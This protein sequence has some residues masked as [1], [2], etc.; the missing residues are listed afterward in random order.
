MGNI[1]KMRAVIKL[2]K[3]YWQRKY[4]TSVSIPAEFLH[5]LDFKH[6]LK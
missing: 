1:K 3:K 2:A 6:L 4:V 5:L